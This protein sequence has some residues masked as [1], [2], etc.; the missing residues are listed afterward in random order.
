[1]IP[2]DIDQTIL[3]NHELST[4]DKYLTDYYSGMIP[5]ELKAKVSR[6][7]LQLYTEIQEYKMGGFANRVCDS[8]SKKFES[9]N[10]A[11]RKSKW[12]K[13]KNSPPLLTNL[14]L[15]LKS[16]NLDTSYKS[17]LTWNAIQEYGPK[18]DNPTFL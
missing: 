8:Y 11:F 12:E 17:S 15:Y 5:P 16:L 7:N 9:C 14:P 10:E 18:E 1:M 6:E 4:S 2:S 13:K 3:R